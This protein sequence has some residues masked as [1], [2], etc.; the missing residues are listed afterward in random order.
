MRSTLVFFLIQLIAF[1]FGQ[2]GFW[3][4]HPASAAPHPTVQVEKNTFTYWSDDAH[5]LELDLFLP[6]GNI[7]Q[8]LPAVLFMHGGGFYTGSRNEPNIEHFCDS[9]A[10]AGYAVANVGYRLT[11]AGDPLKFSCQQS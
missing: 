9:L 7:D 4:Q 1:N 3:S 5:Q 11:L 8:R 6:K 2:I 10:R